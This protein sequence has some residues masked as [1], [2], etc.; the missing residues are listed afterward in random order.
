MENWGRQ[1]Q[2]LLK[3]RDDLYTLPKDVMDGAQKADIADE[4]EREAAMLFDNIMTSLEN[5]DLEIFEPIF[6]TPTL[7]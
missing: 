5:M 7:K 3:K 4:L 2:A 1:I 6:K